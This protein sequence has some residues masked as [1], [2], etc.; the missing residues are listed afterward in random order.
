VSL[1]RELKKKRERGGWGERVRDKKKR[2]SRE[3]KKNKVFVQLVE[4]SAVVARHYDVESV[5][6]AF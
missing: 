1:S 2:S 3:K 5:K 4:S 6:C